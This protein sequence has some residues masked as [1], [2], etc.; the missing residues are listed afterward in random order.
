MRW[1]GFAGNAAVKQLVSSFVDSRRFPHALLLEGAKGSGKKTLARIIAAAAVCES[2]AERPCGDCI[3]C[4]KAFAD[5][6]PDISFYCGDGSARSLHLD[7][8][9]HI[10]DE[11]Y[12]LPN[13]AQK[14]VF[15]LSDAQCMTDRAQN[16]LL[17]VLEEPPAHVLFIL[18]CESRLQLLQTIQSRAAALPLEAVSVDEAL[19]VLQKQLPDQPLEEIRKAFAVFGGYIGQTIDGLQ[20]DDYREVL[21]MLPL[22]V[23]GL[24]APNELSLLQA[25]AP[26]LQNKTLMDGVLSALILVFRDALAQ[27]CH[28]TARLSPVPSIAEELATRATM[29][30]L[31]KLIEVV[32]ETQTSR[33]KNMNT[34]LLITRFCAQLR[35][36]VGR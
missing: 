2:G 33:L 20:G 24:T 10:R 8:I 6:H 29:L 21:E 12:I 26:L 15:V 11:A 13:E 36:A 28:N 19:P 27:R 35:V 7:T 3:H 30:Q 23:E 31:T 9:L 25:T 18:T 14:R 1:N 17:K 34:A 16:T 4:R 32:E 5:V 22:L